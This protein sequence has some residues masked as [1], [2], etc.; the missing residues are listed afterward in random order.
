MPHRRSWQAHQT[1]RTE[2]ETTATEEKASFRKVAG[3]EG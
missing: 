3:E 1:T 2:E